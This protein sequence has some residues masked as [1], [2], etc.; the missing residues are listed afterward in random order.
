MEWMFRPS[1][2]VKAEALYYDLGNTAFNQNFVQ[3][4]GPGSGAPG[5]ALSN[6]STRTSFRNDGI[7]ARAG[8]NYH[9]NWGAA[10]LMAKY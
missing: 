9:F 4:L 7:I 10:P 5:L 2:S 3:T 1:W 8:I 6:T